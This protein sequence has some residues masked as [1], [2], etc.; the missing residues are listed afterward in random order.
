MLDVVK[1]HN[2]LVPPLFFASRYNL[3][4]VE[5]SECPGTQETATFYPACIS[6]NIYRMYMS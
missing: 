1:E 3:L 5:T 6:W 2:E 4:L